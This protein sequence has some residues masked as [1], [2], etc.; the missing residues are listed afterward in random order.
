MPTCLRAFYPEARH[1]RG[2]EKD[3]LY[4]Q[5]THRPNTLPSQSRGLVLWLTAL[6]LE[7]HLERNFTRVRRLRHAETANA[8]TM[9]Y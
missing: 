9:G 6:K 1:A 4:H 7:A 5:E 8:G 2:V 3:F